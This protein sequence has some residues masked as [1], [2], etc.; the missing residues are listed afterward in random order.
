MRK[1]FVSFDLYDSN[2]GKWVG[3]YDFSSEVAPVGKVNRY[4]V[5]TFDYVIVGKDI[6]VCRDNKTTSTID[7]RAW[8][9]L[10]NVE[11]ATEGFRN[12]LIVI[13]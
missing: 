9:T 6:T 10:G 12:L 11:K 5:S 7:T 13:R 8:L 3:T 4:F 2:V 1:L